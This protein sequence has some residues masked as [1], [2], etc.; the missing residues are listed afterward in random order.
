MKGSTDPSGAGNKKGFRFKAALGV[1]KP[2]KFEGRCDD[3][4]GHIYD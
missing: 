2:I 4:K 3:L 1:I